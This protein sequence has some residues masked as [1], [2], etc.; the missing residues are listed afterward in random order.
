MSKIYVF[1]MGNVLTKPT[2]L[3]KVYEESKSKCEYPIFKKLF[4]DS[5]ESTAVYKG[6]ISDYEFFNLLR[7]KTGSKKTSDE[8]RQLYLENKSGVYKDTIDIIK[9]LKDMRNTVCLL[10]NL[11]EVDYE[12]LRNVV[13]MRLF[14]IEFLSYEMGMAKPETDIYKK[15]ID[16]LGTRDFYFFDDTSANVEEAKRLGIDAYQVNGNTISDIFVKQK[17][18]L[19]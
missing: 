4:Y 14:D 5:Y 3:R 16:R 1:D 8:L 15:V 18:L 17:L 19:K 11:K 9:Y 13:D 12:Y 7:E 6:I 2:N 10:S